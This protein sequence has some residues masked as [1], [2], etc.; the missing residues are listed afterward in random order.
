M[1]CEGC[2]YSV[3]FAYVGRRVEVRGCAGV[4][5]VLAEIR[6]IAGHPRHT[7]ERL[8]LDPTHFEGE[9]TETVLPPRRLDG[10]AG[11]CR[12][13]QRSSPSNGQWI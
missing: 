4:V 11:G 6:I 1:S 9:A 13:S 3:P 10:C 8:V 12:R 5:Q 7:L 2:Q